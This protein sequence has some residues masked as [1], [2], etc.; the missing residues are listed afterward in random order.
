MKLKNKQGISLIVLVITIIVM[1]ILAASVVITLSNSGIINKASEATG[2]TNRA[3]VEQYASIVWAEAYM[4]GLRGE[5]LKDAVLEKLEDY[6]DDYTFDVTDKGVNVIDGAVPQLNKYGFYYKQVYL[7]DYDGVS[8]GYAFYQDGSMDMVVSGAAAEMMMGVP[9]PEKIKDDLF[10]IGMQEPGS[11]NY[12]TIADDY[13]YVF[14]EDG[15]TVT[16]E[17]GTV[18]TCQ[19]VQGK[20]LK[21][22]VEY[23]LDTLGPNSEGNLPEDTVLLFN[24]DYVEIQSDTQGTN[25][26][27]YLEYSGGGYLMAMGSGGAIMGSL[28]GTKA[29]LLDSLFVTTGEA[30][31]E[32][33]TEK[34]LVG[35][36]KKRTTVRTG[37][38]TKLELVD[39][40]QSYEIGA[41]V[42]YMPNGVG[43]TSYKGGW[44]LL[45]VDEQGRIL[46]MS[47]QNPH[48]AE[49]SFYGKAGFDAALAAV[50]NAATGYHDGTI[51]IASRSIVP[52]DIV[53]L[54][55]EPMPDGPEI[56]Y[57]WNTTNYP[58]YSYV[59][60]GETKTGSLYQPHK[61]DFTY[62]DVATSTWHVIPKATSGTITTLKNNAFQFNMQSRM[63]MESKVYQMIGNDS[64][65][66]AKI[67][68]RA[69][70]SYP[71]YGLFTFDFDY[72]SNLHHFVS[73]LGGQAT[74]ERG[75]RTVVTLAPGAKLTK[76]A[77]GSYNVSL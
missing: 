74:V 61:T 70:T 30:P 28:D 16:D 46:L 2:K 56:T 25:I 48:G 33:V 54:T 32:T 76:Q 63:N 68:I 60:N 44:K 50:Q 1:I 18:Y 65:W 75:V 19:F 6:T 15:K 31:K 5:D 55:D 57:T 47:A 13:G 38:I 14:S 26:M 12:E 35:N 11:I 9:M 39:A 27:D 71:T 42:N 21:M 43:S 37:L 58:T 4:D 51:G 20:G 45:G 49:L 41:T 3:Q 77:D 67:M 64:Y 73:S 10:F 36:W 17:Q 62:Y 40:T 29:L 72:I 34:A 52:E 7:G 66:L 23:T 69:N 24:K 8:V 53:S 59:E 22:D